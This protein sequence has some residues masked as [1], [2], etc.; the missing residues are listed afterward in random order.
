MNTYFVV[1]NLGNHTLIDADILKIVNDGYGDSAF[2]YVKEELVA[3]A[4]RPVLVRHAVPSDRPEVSFVPPKV[5]FPLLDDLDFDPH[6][7]VD[8]GTWKPL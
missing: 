6:S 4:A 3:F 2:F 7:P 5:P 1:D 8:C